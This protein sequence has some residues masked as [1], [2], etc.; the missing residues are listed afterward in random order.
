MAEEIQEPKLLIKQLR[1]ELQALKK[2]YEIT[3][4]QFQ[5]LKQYVR[6]L[7]SYLDPVLNES[8]KKIASFKFHAPWE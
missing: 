3:D 5:E 2:D 8:V 7:M 4:R 1:Q 6:S